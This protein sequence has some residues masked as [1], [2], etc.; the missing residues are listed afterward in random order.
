[1]PLHKDLK[2]LLFIWTNKFHPDAR[3]NATSSSALRMLT[4]QK[5]VKLF[6]ENIANFIPLV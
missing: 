3:E 4:S 2:H 6:Q 1:M 5:A